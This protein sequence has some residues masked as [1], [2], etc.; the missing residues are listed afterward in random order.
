MDAVT[1]RVESGTVKWFSLDTGYGFITSLS[2]KD[3]YF[4]VRNVVGAKTLDFGDAVTFEPMADANGLKAA[5]I[6]I[7]WQVRQ[8]RQALNASR[9]LIHESDWVECNHCERTMVPQ[10]II[11]QGTVRLK[12]CPHCLQAY[13]KRG[14][15]APIHHI[16]DSVETAIGRHPK[17]AVAII[18]LCLFA[19][20]VLGV[21]SLST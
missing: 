6:K 9:P 7:N 15:V 21:S 13:E 5:N 8:H 10:T 1:G 4:T 11:D 18:F 17:V 20:F 19:S 3:H 16:S 2:G 12:G 14:T